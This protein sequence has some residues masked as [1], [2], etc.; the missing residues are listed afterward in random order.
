MATQWFDWKRLLARLAALGRGLVPL[1]RR[2]VVGG[3]RLAPLGRWLAA[4]AARAFCAARQEASKDKYREYLSDAYSQMRV[5]YPGVENTAKE[6]L[7]AIGV[8]P[9]A[10]ARPT[11]ATSSHSGSKKKTSAVK[12]TRKKTSGKKASAKKTTRK[13]TTARKKTGERKKAA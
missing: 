1:G 5:R 13:T 10:S 4:L 7:D 3:R 9:R 6:A 11:P 2:L 12:K 8:R